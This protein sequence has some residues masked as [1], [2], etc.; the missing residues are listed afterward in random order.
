MS[1]SSQVTDYIWYPMSLDIY[2]VARCMPT[3]G[4]GA[5]VY[6]VAFFFITVRFWAR[7]CTCSNREPQ[8][9]MGAPL[10]HRTSGI[11]SPSASGRPT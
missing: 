9:R 8:Q 1:F 11:G 10:P 4:R 3:V 7:V 6:R 5:I 2:N